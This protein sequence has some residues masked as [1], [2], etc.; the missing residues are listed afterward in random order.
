VESGAFV[1]IGADYYEVGRRT[2][3][4]AERVINGENPKDIPID[5]FIPE[6]MYLNMKL[7]H[8]YGIQIPENVR[9]RAA[10]TLE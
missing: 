6:K 9:K 1:S 2:G 8:E 3:K 7:A 4:V 10:K 5:N